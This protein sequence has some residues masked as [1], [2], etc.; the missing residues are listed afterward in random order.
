MEFG[1]MARG[2]VKILKANGQIVLETTI[3]NRLRIQIPANLRNIVNPPQLV[4]VTIE[5]IG[6]GENKK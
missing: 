4:K 1:Y 2:K 3:T 6:I 5:R